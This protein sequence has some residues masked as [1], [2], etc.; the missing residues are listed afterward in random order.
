[1][2]QHPLY[3]ADDPSSYKYRIPEDVGKSAVLKYDVLLPKGL[4]CTQCV[5]QWTYITGTRNRHDGGPVAAAA[6]AATNDGKCTNNNRMIIV[7]I[8]V[9]MLIILSTMMM[10]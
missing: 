3:L 1:M 9:T 4:T 2:D 10:R 5:V 7:M 6:A 8:T